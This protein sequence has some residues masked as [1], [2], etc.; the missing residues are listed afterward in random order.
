MARWLITGGHGMLGTDL[1]HALEQRG[2]E[3]FQVGHRALD[4]SDKVSVDRYV[5]E[6]QPD[7]IAN[8]AAY[9]KVDDCETNVDHAMK[10]NGWAVEQLADAANRNDSLLLQISTDFVFDGSATR[11]YDINDAV[12]PL[13][14]YG[15]S[16]LEGEERARLARRH[17]ILRTSWL[18][19]THGW[20]FVEAI[21]KQILSGN[22]SL[23]VV[24]DQRGCPT[25]TPHLAGAMIRLAD[26]VRENNDLGGTYHYSDAPA[27][28]WFD[29]ATAIVDE[30][31]A[32]GSAPAGSRVDRTTTA[33]F[34]RPAK[35]PSWSV[36]STER[37][38]RVTGQT[39]ESWRDGLREYFIESRKA[40]AES[41]K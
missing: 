35:R 2:D 13:S 5:D 28:T 39:P 12:A 30:M 36:L 6:I 17:V 18:F 32:D 34:P 41:R 19:G 27:C 7:V 8:C 40:K 3:V 9:T 16:K 1:G 23:R 33:E 4:I 38:E 21:R 15:R 25:Y 14:V 26:R 10:I 29:F 24:D 11:P 31:L 22:T 37:Y 20:N